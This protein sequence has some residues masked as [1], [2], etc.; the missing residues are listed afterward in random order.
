MFLLLHFEN[1]EILKFFENHTPSV[2]ETALLGRSAPK[3]GTPSL[4]EKKFGGRHP[5]I[6]ELR[7]STVVVISDPLLKGDNS[8]NEYPI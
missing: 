2:H 5:A 4:A 7:P 1:F 3:S 8:I 6:T